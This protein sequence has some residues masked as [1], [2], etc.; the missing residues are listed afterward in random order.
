MNWSFLLGVVAA[1]LLV[2]RFVDDHYSDPDH[3]SKVRNFLA[4]RLARIDKAMSSTDAFEAV[5]STFGSVMFGAVAWG[6]IFGVA[7]L[8]GGEDVAVVLAIIL[9]PVTVLLA[10]YF[11]LAIPVVSAIS[12]GLV[13]YGSG[14]WVAVHVLRRSSDPS[15]SPYS[16]LLSMAA[17]IVGVA[18]AAVEARKLLVSSRFAYLN[19]SQNWLVLLAAMVSL[20]I[21]LAL[22]LTVRRYLVR[23]RGET[24][25]KRDMA[26]YLPELVDKDF[27]HSLWTVSSEHSRFQREM[28]PDVREIFTKRLLQKRATYEKQ[29]RSAPFWLPLVLQREIE[30]DLARRDTDAR[31]ENGTSSQ[32]G[33]DA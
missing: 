12:F 31:L 19:T 13:L 7:Y 18:K 32:S 21:V 24:K 3:K 23:R 10:I 1:T 26:L 28:P 6:L 27:V 9:A 33:V 14:K 16:Y 11:A 25:D 22:V 2:A 17:V 5:G 30:S 29:G 8:V 4:E 15:K 20:A